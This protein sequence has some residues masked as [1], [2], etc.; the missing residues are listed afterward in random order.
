MARLASIVAV[1][2]GTAIF[3]AVAISMLQLGLSPHV[4]YHL[5]SWNIPHGPGQDDAGTTFN[6]TLGVRPASHTKSLFFI[7]LADTHVVPEGAC[8][9]PSRTV[10]Q[11]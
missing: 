10:G 4:N 1:C 2:V 8:N 7:D 11:A 9:R 3:T 5:R 6:E